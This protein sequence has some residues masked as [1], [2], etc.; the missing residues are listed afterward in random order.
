[1]TPCSLCPLWLK[2]SVLQLSKEIFSL[3]GNDY[4]GRQGPHKQTLCVKKSGNYVG[5]DRST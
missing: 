4:T 1:M 2:T 5:E 3:Q